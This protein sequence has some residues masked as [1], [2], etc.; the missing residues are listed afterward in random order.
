MTRAT[1][2]ATV[3]TAAM[4][5][6][7]ALAAVVR[8]ATAQGATPCPVTTDDAR[9]WA[10]PL[11]R[12][13]TQPATGVA[14]RT[15]LD[16]VA[17][18]A[19]VRLSY[20]SDVLPLDREACT[21][22][23]AAPLGSVLRALLHG[24]AVTPVPGGA[25]QV[26]L[27]P[28]RTL[29][30]LAART[31]TLDRVV[32][33]GSAA[34]APQRALPYALD[35]VAPRE[36]RGAAAPTLAQALDGAV[37]GLWLWNDAPTTLHARYASVRGASSFGV[38]APK[39]FVDGIELANPLLLTRLAG[40]AVDRVEVIRGP[41]GAALHGA[42]AISGVIHV[43]LRHDGAADGRREATLRSS[44][45][46]AAS[47]FAS[48]SAFTQ[49]HLFA[50]RAGSTG[51]SAGAVVALN[52]IGG[53]VPGGE[54]LQFS[55]DA[56]A[57]SVGARRV[58]SAIASVRAARSETPVNPL[59][60]DSVLAPGSPV[61]GSEGRQ[62]LTHYTVGTTT[63]LTPGAAWTHQVTAG[64]DG[65]RLGGFAMDLVPVPSALDSALRATQGGADR[66][67]LRATSVRRAAFGEALGATVTI[68]GDAALLRDATTSAI[69][70]RVPTFVRPGIAASSVRWLGTVGV[71]VQAGLSW[72]ERVFVSAGLR[73]ERN[74]G[75]TNA[76]R[77]AVLPALG[78][79]LVHTDGPFTW[80]LRV[81]YGEGV[82]PA[83]TPMR[84][85]AWQGWR[86]G[87]VAADLEPERQKGVEAGV[88]LF[89]GRALA[90][91]LT[92]FDQRA[93]S[94][95]QQVPV[96]TPESPF[97]VDPRQPTMRRLGWQLENV[98]AITNR[99]W[100]LGA[101]VALGA[102]AV[103]GTLSLV[104][105][106]V[107]QVA[108]TYTGDLRSGDRMLNVPARTAGLA[109]TWQPRGWQLQGGV[110]HVADWIGYDRLG[111]A[112]DV[113]GGGAPQRSLT[114]EA[115]RA[116]WLRYGGV[117]RVRAAVVRDLRAGLTLRLTGENL[118][119]TQRGEPDNTTIVPGRT[120][121]LGLGARF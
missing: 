18:R 69:P 54:A 56:S 119:G 81:A 25:T 74:D 106:R 4:R 43:Q 89:W 104:Q 120:F 65:Y 63:T 36:V 98:G 12:A 91:Q 115:L 21:V 116:Y 49:E 8:T 95:I 51:R 9:G 80:K 96:A 13:V 83:R 48:G 23:T 47:T 77:F 108:P 93:S 75:F 42:D 62:S 114:G 121:G 86:L 10:P 41:Q 60:A 22:A 61:L 38:S 57:R 29:P 11:D 112:A 6:T 99:G 97:P 20:S 92:R 52:T 105:S 110:T 118:L 45:G 55:V 7:L 111:V 28:G 24:V 33:T 50:L 16:Q 76:S 78:A 94:L 72:R 32:V 3:R 84:E 85:A 31:A 26:V 44:A 64:L 17:A 103:Q 30:P 37:P 15:A 87:A 46:S 58:T 14:L 117:T 107:A 35:V 39:V 66:A 67:S 2:V 1:R 70:A 82:R 113:I 88:D 59:L 5:C 90:L 40:E 100:E 102:V 109:L 71:G 34:G 79:S 101:R 68:A 53:I 27:A 19:G 73:G